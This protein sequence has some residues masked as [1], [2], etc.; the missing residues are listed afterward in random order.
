MRK[1]LPLIIKL[2]PFLFKITHRIYKGYDFLEQA[3]CI[4]IPYK[5]AKA[6][7]QA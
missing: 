6:C 5:N 3:T 4:S 2:C 7:E 1:W